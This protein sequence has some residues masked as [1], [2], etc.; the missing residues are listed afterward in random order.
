MPITYEPINTTTL[1]S[2]QASV[3]FSSIPATYTDLMLVC[4]ARTA[5]AATSDNIIVRFNGDSTTIYSATQLY[6]DT[7]VASA[8]STAN[9]ACFWAYIPGASQT[10][11]TFGTSIMHINNYSNTTTFKNTVCKSANAN[12]Q[13]EITSNL[14]RSTSAISS[15]TVLSGTSSNLAAGSTFTIFGIKAA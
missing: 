5:R 14:Y 7:A 12:A 9:N 11:G 10:A 3:T 1:G 13:L 8:R 2:A 15:I 4:F 6:G